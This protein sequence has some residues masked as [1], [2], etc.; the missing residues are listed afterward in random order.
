MPEC[1]RA[2]HLDVD[3][4]A[5]WRIC[6]RRNDERGRAGGVKQVIAI[7]QCRVVEVVG[8]L[9]RFLHIEAAIGQLA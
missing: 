4:A 9:S 5:E 2:I 1:R 8:G 3:T 6:V 7:L